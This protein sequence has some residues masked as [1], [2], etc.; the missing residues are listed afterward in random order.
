MQQKGLPCDDPL[1]IA[2]TWR[3]MR[4]I[5]FQKG[6]AEKTA[7]HPTLAPVPE[8]RALV[9]CARQFGRRKRFQHTAFGIHPKHNEMVTR[10]FQ[11]QGRHYGKRGIK[12]LH[13]MPARD[14]CVLPG[15]S[16]GL[17]DGCAYTLKEIGDEMDLTRERVRQ[18]TDKTLDKLRNGKAGKML[19]DFLE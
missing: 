15:L 4:G 5:P 9:G 10:K 12:I 3:G 19:Q 8:A 17:E 1:E 18:V 7:H 14:A 11:R 2:N 6:A 13:D 16:S